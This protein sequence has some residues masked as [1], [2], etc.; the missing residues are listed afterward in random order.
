MKDNDTSQI[1][2]HPP[3]LTQVVAFQKAGLMDKANF[4][5]KEIENSITSG[6]GATMG[7]PYATNRRSGYG[8]DLLWQSADSL[9]CVSSAAWY[10]FG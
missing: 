7:I 9:P 4:Y 8:T 2:N 5:L 1:K 6:P 3:N 10:L